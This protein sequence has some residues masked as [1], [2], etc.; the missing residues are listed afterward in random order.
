MRFRPC[1]DLHNG[2]VK[3]IVGATLADGREPETNFQAEK[4]AAWY[5]KLYKQDH[6]PGG[7]IIQ[8]GPGNAA[9]AKSALAAWPGGLQV[10]G[11]VDGDNAGEW[12]AAGAAAVIVTSW[13]FHDGRI[14]K[15]RLDRLVAGVGRDR[16]VLDLSCRRRDDDYYIVTDRWQTFTRERITLNLLDSLAV[17][18]YLV[19]LSC[20]LLPCL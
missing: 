15:T 14:D 7:H 3:Q 6:L 1:I 17:L 13:V 18:P 20:V 10:G 2:R 19:L 12:I 5:A 8:L 9:A 4:P 16:L 11:G